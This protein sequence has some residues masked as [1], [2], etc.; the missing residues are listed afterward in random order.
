MTT[1][2]GAVLPLTAAQAEIWFDEQFTTGPLAYNMADYI[3]LR[4]PLDTELLGRALQRLGHEAEGL[5]VQFVEEAGA[6]GQI[7]RPLAQLP[8]KSMDFSGEDDPLAAAERWM[9][10]DHA[11]PLRV[12]DFPLFRGALI[13]LGPEHHLLYLCMHH[14]LAD[15]FSRALLYPKLAA[16]YTRLAAGG[17]EAE[18]DGDAIPPFHRLLDAERDY[19]DS[20]K[21]DRDRAYWTGRLTAGGQDGR[22]PELVSFSA[23]EP[24]RGRGALRHTRR[25]DAEA[26]DALRA[27]AADG[28]VTMPV[29]MVAAMAAYAQRMTGVAEPLLTLPV[30]GRVGAISREIPGMLANYLPLAV[31]VRPEMTRSQL[32][33]QAWVEVSGAL[34]HQRYRGDRIRRDIGLHIDDRRAFGPFINVLNQD[35]QLGF[36]DT[37]RGTVVNLSTGI[38][39]DLIM[40]VLNTADGT[41]EIH[42]DGNPELY[43]SAELAAHLARFVAFLADLAA[44]PADRPLGQTGLGAPG[45]P[46]GVLGAWDPA[47]EREAYEGL[48]E[49]VRAVAARTPDAVAV[50]DGTRSVTYRELLTRAAGVASR[51]GTARIATGS[52]VAML[53]DPGVPFVAGVLGV[54]GAGGA[55]LPLD[56]AAP[57]ARNAAL[58]KDSGARFLLTGSAYREAAAALT[59]ALTAADG[60]RTELT[61]LALA[62]PA[63]ADC[64]TEL[65]AVGGGLD[66][67]YVMFTS[68]STGRPKGAMVQR[69]GMVNHLWAKVGDLDL[70]AGETV[71]QNAPLTFDVSVWQML[72]PLLV[73]GQVRVSGTEMAADPAALFT[74]AHTEQITVLEV[75][76]SLLRAALD[77][78]DLQDDA[79]QLPDLRWLMVTGEALPGDLCARWHTRYPHIPLMNAYGP[80]ECSDDVTHAVITATDT[81]NGRVPIGA[82][83]RNTRL[84]VLSDELQPVPTGTPGELYVGGA[85]V[86]RGYLHDPARTATTFIADPFAGPGTRM[87]RT[88]DRVIQRPDGQLEFIERRD[89]QVKIRGRRVETG[90]IE[91]VIRGLDTVVDAAVAVLPDASGNP[92]LFGYLTGPDV[93]AARVRA[94]L[95][96]LLPAYMIPASWLVLDAMPLT[97]NGKL[98][99][100]AL[101]KPAAVEQDTTRGPRDERERI[102]CGI[103]G[104]VLGQPAVGIDEDFFALGGDSIRSIQVV[105]RARKAG[106]SLTTRDIF[107]HKTVAALARTA[108]GV[109]TDSVSGI[110]TG[111]DGTGVGVY[112]LT[113]IMGQL[114]EDTRSLTGPVVKYSQHVV[115]RVPAGL[116]A[117]HLDAAL[118]AVVDHH[119]A[120]RTRATE[121]SPGLWQTEVLAPG[122]LNGVRLV[123]TVDAGGAY[124]INRPADTTDTTGSTDT[125]DS[126]DS[127]GSSDSTTGAGTEDAKDILGLA[128]RQAA[129]ARARLDP[130]AAV[131]I[132]AVLLDAGPGAGTGWLVLCAHHLVV[133]GVSWRIL[134]PDL[135]A[136]CQALA[137]GRT[138][139]LDPVGTSYRSW[140]RLL[141]EQARTQVRGGELA[142]WQDILEGPD[143]LVGT[144][145]LDPAQDIY[146]TR[147]GLRLELGPDLTGPLL[148]DVPAAFHAQVNDVLLTGLALAVADWRRRHGHAHYAQTLIELEGHG[149]EQLVDGLDLSRTVGWFTS[150]FPV[151]LDPGPLDWDEVWAGGPALSGALKRIK[152]QLRALPDRGV[153]HGLLRYLNPHAA[154]TLSGYHRPQIGF[155]YMGRFDAREAG[156]WEPAGGDGVVGTGAHPGMPL[157]HLIDVTP[158]TEDRHDGPHLIANWAWAGQAVADEDAHDIA[159]T[160]FR[161][162]ELLSRHAAHPD[163]GG[164]TPSDLPLVEV[165]QEEIEEYEADLA[166]S[167]TALADILPLT[168]LQQ[169]MLFHAEYDAAGAED[170]RNGRAGQDGQEAVDVYTLQIVAEVAGDLDPAVLRAAGQALLD[171]HPNLRAGFRARPD[172]TPVQIVP[173]SA[174]LPWREADLRHLPEA[175]R[176][177]ELDRITESE[178]TRRF[179]LAAPPLLRFTL[180]THGEERHRF[181]WTSHHILVD[182]WSMPLLVKELFALCAP[183]ADVT[184]LPDPAPYRSYLAWLTAQDRDEARRAW[185][186]VL[187]DVTEPTL[188]VP[189][190]PDRAPVLP[191]SVRAEVSPELTAALAGWA[192]GQGLTLN[193]V[194]QG[195]WALLLGRLTGRQDVVFGAVT[196]GRPAEVPDVESMIGIFLTTVPVR[197]RLRP[198]AT[199]TEL[200]RALQDQQTALLPHEHLGLVEIHKAAGLSGEVFDT[201]VLFENFPLDAGGLDT[202]TSDGGPRV[203]SAE[204]RDARHHPLSMAVFPGDAL[205]LRLDYAPDLFTRADV[206]RIA[207]MFEHLLRTV[208]EHPELPIARIDVTAPA[209]LGR[210]GVPGE[211]GGLLGTW[212]PSITEES[213]GVVER[214]RSVADRIPDGTAVTD[215]AGS[216]TYREL[217]ES[218][219][220]LSQSL[221]GRGVATGSVVAMLADP[222]VPF[223]AGVLGVLGAGGAYLPLDP[224]APVARNAALLKD[225][226][227]RFLLVGAGY[228]VSARELTAVQDTAAPVT[229]IALEDGLTAR[230]VPPAVGDGLD[231]AY[232]MF[233]SGSTGRPKGAMVQ[234]SGMVNHLWAKVG[235]LDLAAGETV[236]QN[237]PLT[238]DVS[239]WQMLAPLLVGGQVRVSGTEMAADPAA[240]FTMAHTEQITVL[241]VVPSLLR[242]ALDAWDLQDDAPQLPDLRWL[243]VT[244]EA[245]PADLCTRWHTR[246]PHIPLMNAYGPTECSDDVTHAV[247]TATDTLNGRVPIGAPVRNTRLYVLSDEL[248]PVPTGTPGELY[249]GGAGVGRGYLHDPARTATT[250]MADPFAGPGTRMYRTG[251]RVIQRPDGQ[252]E[253]I[254][255]RDHQVKIR[256]RRVE[257][258]E[259]EAVVRGLD[260]VADAA[261]AVVP[262]ASGNPRLVGYLSGAGTAPDPERVQQHLSGLLPAYMIPVSWLVLDAMPLTPNGKLDRK[263]LPKPAHMDEAERRGPRDEPERVLCG[264]FGEVLGQ[265]A[266]GIDEDFFAL[267]GDSIRSIQVVSRAR[268]AGLS[269]TTR[270]IFTHK[271]VAAL[272]RTA[273]ERE[274]DEPPV[275]AVDPESS[276]IALSDEELADLE[277]ELSE[278]LS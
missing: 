112:E 213:L 73:G 76:P 7:V 264:I 32:L 163:A 115:V 104:E 221:T 259:I 192:R 45:E 150:A 228:E 173:Q 20:P 35:P 152:E 210:A 87:Y 77:A 164:R 204:A 219:G 247:I 171:R 194:V 25:L 222:G 24:A 239:V 74:M 186:A 11:E 126:T 2:R 225:S 179:D 138:P 252:L 128:E 244:G 110:G 266:V 196:S 257:L 245:L 99:R 65:P 146:G 47:A 94:E 102:L 148:T 81:L 166:R 214:V 27:M 127:T 184:A 56:P 67:A 23:Q 9:R 230:A 255:R 54:L 129:A 44:M 53:A 256:G 209:I 1:K 261:V 227:A 181:I 140:S 6:P 182:G 90:E 211:F 254:E 243:M 176:A 72:A 231:L 93:D 42:L 57:V 132:Q 26:T 97:P 246:Y 86:G 229:V 160:W 175:E 200:L 272:A 98:D 18:L 216:V 88:G 154:R 151:R 193:S 30:T 48:V 250:F 121:P 267:G 195:C 114:H 203:V 106:L 215:N 60:D 82:P 83:V 172:G 248:Q 188:L 13:T 120:L 22:A 46:L 234:R 265:P 162:L 113:P 242:A 206:E 191:D 253:F 157:P 185:S 63:D 232:V 170:G 142:L 177:A 80:T 134:L 144:R 69:S 178:R 108:G 64:A 238:F 33:R 36:G 145:R 123:A 168:P 105:S 4:G 135:E 39:N 158:A 258:G 156:L 41:M 100:K 278:D 17:T 147:R 38:V 84:Y 78:W 155:N 189:A 101:P 161:A 236:V 276:L 103:F 263:A 117:D 52:V 122:A 226:G 277:L 49:R 89:H 174:E 70:A 116:D 187:G 130:A 143:P 55:Y 109:D 241:E 58:L 141:I 51:L 96:Q 201:V 270:D 169:G 149:R 111:D 274:R 62:E 3:E 61:A 37:C 92:R 85:G 95:A 183:G 260:G 208:A 262:D 8:L 275:P 159:Q 237:A 19:L 40:T 153:G 12:T 271:T 217:V 223:V 14:I 212:D 5:R 133:D 198:G 251:D 269:L 199:L 119:D 68:G 207:V 180:V 165:A 139:A 79:P 197:T 28:K 205:N 21:V 15:G 29:L 268:K 31:R 220:G 190:D 167:G 91:A 124:G 59:C 235:D 240:L 50:A 34:K 118:H 218:A 10:A 131:M 16:L 75:V 125:T 249:V 137:E 224:A 233:T 273:A 66:L 107:T 71:V 43:D 202:G 136:A